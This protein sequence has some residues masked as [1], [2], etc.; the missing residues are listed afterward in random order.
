MTRPPNRPR[1]PTKDELAA[2]IKDQPG[3]VGK[4]EIA[5]AFHVAPA[6]RS[7]LRALIKQLEQD[8]ALE[9]GRNRKLSTPDALPPV[10]VLIVERQDA[11]GDLWAK[12]GQRVPGFTPS[13]AEGEDAGE[14]EDEKDSAVPPNDPPEILVLGEHF[15]GSGRL[16]GKGSRGRKTAPRKGA[17]IGVG[18]R[19]LAKLRKVGQN[20]YEARPIKRLPSGPSTLLGMLVQ[21]PDGMRLRPTDRRDRKEYQ[22]G[23]R[24]MADASHGDFVEAELLPSGRGFGLRRVKVVKRLSANAGDASPSLIAIHAQGIPTRFSDDALAQAEAATG[25][26]LEQ[27]TDLRA[28]PLVTIDGEDARDFDDAVWAEALEGGGWRVLVA[29]ADVS[30]YV[31]PGDALDQCAKDRGNSVY[32][33]DRVV[34]MLPEALSNGWCSLRPKEDRPCMAVE[35]RFDAGGRKTDHRFMRGL[36]RSAARLTYTQVQNARD[37]Q[38]DDMTGPLKDSVLDP[39]YAVFA[40]LDRRRRE[41]GALELDLPERQILIGEDGAVTGVVPRARLDSHRLIEELMIAANVAAAETL[42][43]RAKPCMY[44]VHDRPSAEK[45]RGL[46]EVLQGL[47]IRFPKTEIPRAALFNGVLAQVKGTENEHLINE[48]ILRSQ[49]QAEYAPENIGHFGLSLRRYAHFTSPIRRY[50]D[51]LVHRALIAG[52]GLGAGGLPLES[53]E[54]EFHQIGTHITATERRAAQAERD[55]VNRFTV[56]FLANRTGAVFAGRIAGA[57]RAGLFVKLEETGADGLLPMSALPRDYYIHDDETHCLIGEQSGQVFRVGMAVE[58]ML[59]EA[60][61]LTG[62]LLF[63]LMSGGEDGKGGRRKSSGPKNRLGRPKGPPKGPP[64]GRPRKLASRSRP[65]GS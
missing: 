47:D 35:M 34:P 17:E 36:M 64:K 58:V 2:F 6:D 63:A 65:K 56:R 18:D 32:F 48:M 57:T 53:S 16:K 40:A 23:P 38:P 30:W 12:L 59:T 45:A 24:D 50:A 19:V 15:Q 11:E 49:A 22:V 52:L 27:R 46:S 5:R 37:G 14:D 61:P 3:P 4:R 1:L 51:L 62:G 9:R 43:E 26:P 13:E 31:R 7:D 55:A 39:L 54:K 28:V 25:A 29:I 41:R 21:G 20:R 60:D 42:E 10:C 33:P 8:G 44:R